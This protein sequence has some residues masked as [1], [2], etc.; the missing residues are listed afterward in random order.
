MTGSIP[1]PWRYCVPQLHSILYAADII[2]NYPLLEPLLSTLAFP[3]VKSE[4]SASNLSLKV[5]YDT[6]HFCWFSV[7]LKA[8][9]SFNS[10]VTSSFA[11]SRGGSDGSGAKY[12]PVASIHKYV[13]VLLVRHMMHT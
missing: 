7:F 1:P 2:S 9:R 12:I 6:S 4:Y 8:V 5:R 11:T 13:G 3:D 10:G